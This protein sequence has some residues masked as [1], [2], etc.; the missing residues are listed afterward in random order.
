M[1][2]L[3]YEGNY[4]HDIACCEPENSTCGGMCRKR[5]I[6]ERLKAYEDTGLTPEKIVKLLKRSKSSF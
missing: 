4:C 6:W 2:R 3:T 1:K 5:E